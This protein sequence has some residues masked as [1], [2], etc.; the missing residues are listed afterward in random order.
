MNSLEERPMSLLTITRSKEWKNMQLNQTEGQGRKG[1]EKDSIL[2]P[3]KREG[4]PLEFKGKPTI[5]ISSR[6]HCGETPASYML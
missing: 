5:I 3:N 1:K 6:V 4:R 2:Y